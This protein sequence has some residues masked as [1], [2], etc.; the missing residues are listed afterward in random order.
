MQ[1]VIT[2]HLSR[3][4]LH[5]TDTELKAITRLAIHGCSTV[6]REQIHCERSMAATTS[7][8]CPEG[9][10]EEWREGK[11]EGRGKSGHRSRA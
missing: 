9:R 8:R 11:K 10:R 7:N 3:R 4:Q 6:P 5:T 2:H 1:E